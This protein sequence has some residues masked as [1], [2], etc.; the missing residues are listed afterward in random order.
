VVKRR[1]GIWS[2]F[3]TV[4]HPSAQGAIAKHRIVFSMKDDW[5]TI[6]PATGTGKERF[7]TGL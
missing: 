2:G 5:K 7:V 3:T 1:R 6:S 4:T